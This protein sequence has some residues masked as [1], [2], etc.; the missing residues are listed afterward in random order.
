MSLT[1][2]QQIQMELILTGLML[3]GTGCFVII[4]YSIK[5]I[6]K[7]YKKFLIN[8]YQK[9]KKIKLKRFKRLSFISGFNKSLKKNLN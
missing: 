4:V 6:A 8:C 7:F 5:R 9:G 2:K 1:V 3:V